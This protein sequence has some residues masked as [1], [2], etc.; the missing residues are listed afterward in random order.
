MSCLSLKFGLESGSQTML[1]L[2]EKKFTT[3]DIKKAIY[4]CAEIGLHTP[5]LGFMIGMP[6]ESEE[7]IKESGQLAGELYA[8]LKIPPYYIWGNVDLPYAIPLVGTP[9]YEY[10][11]QLGLIGNNVDEEANYLEMTSNVAILKRFYI[12]FSCVY[13]KILKIYFKVYFIF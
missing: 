12:N 8:K 7:T 10:G 5:L 2:M 1:D 4:A 11:K 3:E 9:L 6:G 13:L